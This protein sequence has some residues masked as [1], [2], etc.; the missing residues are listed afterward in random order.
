MPRVRRLD[1]TTTL[2]VSSLSND[3]TVNQLLQKLKETKSYLDKLIKASDTQNVEP[4]T[5][6]KMEDLV[7]LWGEIQ[8]VV[9]QLINF[10]VKVAPTSSN[11]TFL[12]NYITDLNNRYASLQGQIDSLLN[13]LENKK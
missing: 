1:A 7:I 9:Y 6:Q 8:R 13:S 12:K 2:T 10:V 3:P 5:K 11:T 4:V